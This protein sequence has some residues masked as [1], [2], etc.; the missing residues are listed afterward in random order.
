MIC[1]FYFQNTED[2]LTD[3]EARLRDVELLTGLQFYMDYK[4]SIQ[5]RTFLPHGLWSV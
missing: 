1:F 4:N 2:Y 3:N 5:L